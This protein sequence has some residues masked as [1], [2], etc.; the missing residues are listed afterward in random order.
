MVHE[1]Q[2][3]GATPLSQCS[4][5]IQPIRYWS[6]LTN[7]CL[8]N[9][10]GFT[11]AEVLITIAIIG[12]VSALT[13]PT[14][15]HKYQEYSLKV[16]FK[17]TYAV[18]QQVMRRAEYDFGVQPKCYY[19][20]VNPYGPAVC[21]EYS[22][23][24]LTCTGGYVLVST[25]KPIPADYNGLTSDCNEFGNNI[26]QN[27]RISKVCKTKPYENGCV[28]DYE[29]QDTYN[30]GINAALGMPIAMKKE[31]LRNVNYTVVLS[32]GTIVI[33]GW[34]TAN[35]SPQLFFVDTNGMKGPNKWGYDIFPFRSVKDSAGNLKIGQGNAFKEDGGKT[36]NE[37]LQEISSK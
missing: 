21:K 30:G 5:W 13:I 4:R 10:K 28:P 26:M 16:Q 9:R 32:D 15:V 34:G 35:I 7:N 3:G 11:L 23:D 14:L 22:D 25:G 37:M 29:G 36:V 24:G 8:K 27:L 2:R 31:S 33:N 17:K 18:L 19:W 20:G 1:T 12:I 6:N